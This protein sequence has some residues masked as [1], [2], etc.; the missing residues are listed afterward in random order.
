MLHPACTSADDRRW[1]GGEGLRDEVMKVEDSTGSLEAAMSMLIRAML[2]EAFLSSDG[3]PIHA[4][5]CLLISRSFK[6]LPAN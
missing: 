6:D 3:T 2:N 4:I 5:Y 1:E